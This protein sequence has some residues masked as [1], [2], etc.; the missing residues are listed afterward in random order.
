MEAFKAVNSRCDLGPGLHGP[1]RRSLEGLFS[2]IHQSSGVDQQFCFHTRGHEE[3]L[4]CST[5]PQ[6]EFID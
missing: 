1:M 5:K 6:E 2:P 4:C 3:Q